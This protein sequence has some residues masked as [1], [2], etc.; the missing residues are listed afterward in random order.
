MWSRWPGTVGTGGGAEPAGVAGCGLAIPGLI[1]PGLEPARVSVSAVGFG[2]IGKGGIRCDGSKRNPLPSG[3]APLGR[4]PVGPAP[5]VLEPVSPEVEPSG[6]GRLTEPPPAGPRGFSLVLASEPSPLGGSSGPAGSGRCLGDG[7]SGCPIGLASDAAPSA[8]PTARPPVLP[9][10]GLSGR[11]GGTSLAVSLS[12][13]TGRASLVIGLSDSAGGRAL[14]VG[15]SGLGASGSG[16]L[17][18]GALGV[19][20]LDLGPLGVGMRG[21]VPAGIGPGTPGRADDRAPL[22]SVLE[23]GWPAEP[24]LSLPGGIEELRILFTSGIVTAPGRLS[25][26]GVLAP[27]AVLPALPPTAAGGSDG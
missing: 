5:G 14:G 18:I 7:P 11:T 26:V 8:P 23:S 9:A 24:A 10:V 4:L 16:E 19:G 3:A 2:E 12:R 20:A 15:A 17:A 25:A 1:V 6:R 27:P 13:R 21:V 22:W